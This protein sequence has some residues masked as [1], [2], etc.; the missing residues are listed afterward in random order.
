MTYNL[1]KEKYKILGDS[2]ISLP[3]AGGD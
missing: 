3:S 1:G 2:E